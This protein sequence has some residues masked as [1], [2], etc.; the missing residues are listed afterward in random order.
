[1]ILASTLPYPPLHQDKK[2][3]VLSDWDGTITTRDTNDCRLVP[4]VVGAAHS[5]PQI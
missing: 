3:V 5:F 1:M 4:L 2:F